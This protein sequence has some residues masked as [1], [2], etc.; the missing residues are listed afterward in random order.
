M[1]RA[2]TH[3]PGY[4]LGDH[5]GYGTGAHMAAIAKLGACPIHR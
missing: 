1:R 5:K 3:W 4:G 2:E